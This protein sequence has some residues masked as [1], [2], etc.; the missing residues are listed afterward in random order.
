MSQK[1]GIESL[2]FLDDRNF[3]I[4]CDI[5]FERMEDDYLDQKEFETVF[6]SLGKRLPLEMEWFEKKQ[7]QEQ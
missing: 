3:E 6:K 5:L 4:L 1:P 7:S 2:R